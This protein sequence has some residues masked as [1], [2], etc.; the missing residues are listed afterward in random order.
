MSL[1]FMDQIGIAMDDLSVRFDGA[2]PGPGGRKLRSMITKLGISRLPLLARLQK[3]QDIITAMTGNAN[4]ATPNPPLA[5]VQLQ[6]T[7]TLAA[8]T[9][10]DNALAEA[11]VKMD[12][13]TDELDELMALLTQLVTYVDHTANG[14]PAIIN[15]SGMEVRASARPVGELPRPRRWRRL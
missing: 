6:L 8:F 13:R 10:F 4:F 15:S 7:A 12:L 11:R 3:V 14:D 1:V 2:G 9:A 5:T